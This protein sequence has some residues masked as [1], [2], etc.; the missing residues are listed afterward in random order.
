MID[1]VEMSARLRDLAAELDLPDVD[2]R[3]TVLDRIADHEPAGGWAR[4][5]LLAAAIV[6]VALVAATVA[7]AP[8]RDAVASWLG[9]GSTTLRRAPTEEIPPGVPLQLGTEIPVTD[10]APSLPLLGEPDA[11]FVDDRGAISSVW[12]ANGE[13]PELGSTGWGAIL[14]IRLAGSAVG[15]EKLLGADTQV[16]SVVIGTATG[17]WV[18]GDHIVIVPGEPPASARHVLLWV[19]DGAEYRLETD[20]PK[21]RAVELAGAVRGTADG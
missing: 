9:I 16:E 14:T 11:A 12:V 21:E 13:L 20:L 5:R 8:A 17:L 6:V 4:R 10:E 2:L 3:D 7:I 15:V 1:D 18:P 19:A